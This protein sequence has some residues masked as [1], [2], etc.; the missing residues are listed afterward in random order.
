ME[1]RERGKEETEMPGPRQKLSVLEANGRKHLSKAEKA[2]RAAQEVE[3]PKPAKMRVPRWLPEHLK[4]DFRAL[5]KE[6][7]AA[8]MGAAQLDRDTVGRYLVAQHQ[9]TAA[10]R[11]V[12]DALDQEDPDMVNKWTRAQKSYFEQARACAN[13]LGLTIT[14]RCRLVV[15]E[16]RKPEENPF[17]Q[18]MEARRRA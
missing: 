5:A 2:A 12:Q 13:D 16:A 10:C 17:L 15:P 11:M 4:A 3:L 9:F 14:S 18:L 7:L 6:L 1:E 8:D